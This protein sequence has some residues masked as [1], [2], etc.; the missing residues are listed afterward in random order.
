MA[1]DAQAQESPDEIAADIVQLYYDYQG[2]TPQESA[3]SADLE[4][5]HALLARGYSRED[6][7]VAVVRAHQDV[8]AAGVQPLE[9][10]L[11]WYARDHVMRTGS[12]IIQGVEIPPDGEPFPDEAEAVE[13]TRTQRREDLRLAR[14]YA[15]AGLPPFMSSYML[16][17]MAAGLVPAAAGSSPGPRPALG[18]IPL[19]GPMLVF[20][21]SHEHDVGMQV[22]PYLAAALMLTAIQTT[23][24][25][26]IA[27]SI[28]HAKARGDADE[29]R[30]GMRSRRHG[31]LTLVP[32]FE[33][34]G[35]G[36]ALCVCF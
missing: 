23:G 1:V 25:V 3:V 7:T 26:L 33:P 8:P 34:R 22:G 17:I 9:D 16:T 19:A 32:T 31:W 13:V 4:A 10:V 24:A 35:G 28:F 30:S 36:V 18:A 14:T 27:L 15:T 6:L 11:P 12:R 2:V 5:I 20:G 21:W 29:D